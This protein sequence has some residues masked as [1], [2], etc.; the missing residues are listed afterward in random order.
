LDP[1]FL[2]LRKPIWVALTDELR[3][4]V[5]SDEACARVSLRPV[6][7]SQL[8]AASVP[9]TQ[10]PGETS[11]VIAG[12]WNPAILAPTWVLQFGLN[13]PGSNEPVQVALP[14]GTVGITDYPRFT[15]PDFAYIVRP[16]TLVLIPPDCSPEAIG[17]MEEAAASM[18]ENLPHTPVNGVGHNFEF[19]DVNPDPD[20]LNVFTQASQDLADEAP[21]GWSSVATT[22]ASSFRSANG[23]T[24]ANIQRQFDGANVII[25]FNFHHPLTTVQQALE[26]LRG[27]NGHARMHQNFQTARELMAKL[28]GPVQ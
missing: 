17:R 27:L 9:I 8:G 24:I 3:F 25:K 5:H 4:V 2:L 10:S 19:R 18:L 22:I 28:Y 16:E 1:R 23:S 11:L 6:F 20:K 21:E 13:R 7:E 12:A 26:I 14:A 15:F